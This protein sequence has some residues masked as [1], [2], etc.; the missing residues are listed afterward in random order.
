M[1]RNIILCGGGIKGLL[2]I[3]CMKVWEDMNIMN[4]IRTLVGCSVGSIFCFLI[5]IRY[6]ADEIIDL[7]MAFQERLE[8]QKEADL[9]DNLVDL[10]SFPETYGI[11]N[12]SIIYDFFT[13]ALKRK[14]GL[15]DITFIEMGKRF[16]K[17]MVICG[18]NLTNCNT[19][20]FNMDTHPDMSILLAMRISCSV[21]FIFTPVKYNDCLY[22]DGGIYNNFPFEYVTAIDPLRDIETIGVNIDTSY[23]KIESLGSYITVLICSMADRAGKQKEIAQLKYVCTIGMHSCIGADMI[24]FSMPKEDIMKFVEKGK[25]EMKQYMLVRDTLFSTREA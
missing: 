18:A 1:I 9:E 10:F 12:G 22:V 11:N 23:G 13:F 7:L 25:V 24:N 6:S 3:G 14:T 21:P 4:D 16:G 2:F 8:Q 17:N 15:E 20:Y 19:D 5:A